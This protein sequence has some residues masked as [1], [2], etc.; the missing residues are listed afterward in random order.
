[1]TELLR[2][3]KTLAAWG[4][5][6]FITTLKREVVTS[7]LTDNKPFGRDQLGMHVGQLPE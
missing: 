3:P 6:D 5:A 7:G 4:T 2:L 1:M